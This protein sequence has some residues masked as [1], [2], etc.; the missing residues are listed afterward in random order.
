MDKL[1]AFIGRF[2][3]DLGAAVH[4]GMVVIGEKLGLYKA[5]PKSRMDAS[6]KVPG[7]G[8]ILA[9]HSLAVFLAMSAHPVNIAIHNISNAIPCP[10][11][12]RMPRVTPMAKTSSAPT[13]QTKTAA[14]FSSGFLSW[15][16]H[17]QNR[18]KVFIE[19][20]C[21]SADLTIADEIAL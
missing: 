7:G 9:C 20:Y 1:N 18:H 11:G 10:R 6:I 14:F 15:R 12:E 16:M 2:V 13:Q 8:E 5:L 3:T 21:T 17:R 19:S 4:T